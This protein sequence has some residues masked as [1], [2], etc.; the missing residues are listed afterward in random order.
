VSSGNRAQVGV[1]AETLWGQAVTVN[2]FYPLVNETLGQNIGRL[3]SAGIIAGARILRSDQW[4]PDVATVGGDLGL[5]LFQQ[6]TGLLFEHMLGSITSSATGGVATHTITPGSLDGKSL[7]VQVGKPGTGG[8]VHPFTYAGVKVQ[9]WELAVAA[10][11]IVTL[12]LTLA[13]KSETTGIALATASYATD[14][15]PFRYD[16]GGVTLSSSSFCVRALTLRGENPMDVNRRCIGQVNID[17]PLENDLRVYSGTATL[18]FVDLTQYQRFLGTTEYPV[19]LSLSASATAQATITMNA[20]FDGASPQVTGRGLVMIETPFKC[21]ASTSQ[22]S[23]A[24]T[25]TLKNTQ[26]TG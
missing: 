16:Q 18:E 23:S 14:Y 15:R 2:R 4:T 21:L 20:R 11:E 13:A 19:V 1:V 26:T 10:G 12:G 7:T 25:V 9:S 22:D 3:E 5:E 24:I 8:T 6:Q 17:Q